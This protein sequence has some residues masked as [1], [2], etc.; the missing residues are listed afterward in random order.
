[1]DRRTFITLLGSAAIVQFAQAQQAKVY[2][3]G[4]IHEGGPSYDVGDGLKD[5]LREL[6]FEEGKQYVVEVTI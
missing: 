3:V 1:M 6:G 4:V 5:G 2:R